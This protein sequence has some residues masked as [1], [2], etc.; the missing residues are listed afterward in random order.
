MIGRSAGR[1]AEEEC[2]STVA[3]LNRPVSTSA[4]RQRRYRERKR[5]KI[6]LA[7]VEIGAGACDL[8]V[9][10]GTL[11]ESDRRNPPAVR[12]AFAEFLRYALRQA[13]KRPSDA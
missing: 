3:Q 7:T 12:T 9:R 8:F 11:A 6:T 13:E 4:A 1:K 2:A 10:L 5:H